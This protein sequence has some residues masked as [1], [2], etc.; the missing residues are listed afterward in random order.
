MRH[1]KKK[2]LAGSKA[3]RK[4]QL[5]SLLRAFLLYER[6]KTTAS[7]AKIVSSKAEKLITLAKRDDLHSRRLAY[8][9]LQDHNL[10][11]RLFEE[12]GPRFKDRT[13]GYT[14][15][16]P[17][18]FRKGDSAEVLILEF[19][20]FKG[21]KERKGKEKKETLPSPKTESKPTLKGAP[22]KKLPLKGGLR[23]SLRRIFKKERDAL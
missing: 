15:C 10:V 9:V 23:Q 8:G 18:G 21:E 16:I 2:R 20:V 1:R 4:A 14:R 17:L 3:F 5:R 11:K 6:I 12:I 19:V 7:K 22:K 13:G